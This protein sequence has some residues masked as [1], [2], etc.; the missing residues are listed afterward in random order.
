MNQSAAVESWEKLE[1]QG[2]HGIEAFSLEFRNGI[3]TEVV[4]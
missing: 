1:N 3:Q 4:H 2:N